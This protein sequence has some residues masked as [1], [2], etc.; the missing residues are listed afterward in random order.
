MAPYTDS[1]S[2]VAI[3]DVIRRLEE[4]TDLAVDI[5]APAKMEGRGAAK[6]LLYNRNYYKGDYNSG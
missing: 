6:N 4:L 5:L 1:L 3:E 2:P